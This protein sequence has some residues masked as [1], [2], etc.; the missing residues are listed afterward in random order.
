MA[1]G[2]VVHQTS[3]VKQCSYEN[4]FS[5]VFDG[6][7]QSFLV[8]HVPDMCLTWNN[9]LECACHTFSSFKTPP[10]VIRDMTDAYQ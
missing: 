2:P 4:E 6:L 5:S 8:K 7:H 9:L 3:P 10:A 1:H